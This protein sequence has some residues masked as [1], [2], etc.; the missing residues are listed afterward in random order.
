[1]SALKGS[2]LLTDRRAAGLIEIRFCL[3]LRVFRIGWLRVPD[4]AALIIE[5]GLVVIGRQRRL[6]LLAHGYRVA[7]TN[8]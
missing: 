8:E 5:A 2:L 6:R 1:M 4:G 3:L 7:R